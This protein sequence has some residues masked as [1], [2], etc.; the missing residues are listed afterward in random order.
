MNPGK[1]MKGFGS[2]LS[3]GVDTLFGSGGKAGPT[4]A[5]AL[6]KQNPEMSGYMDKQGGLVKSWNRRYF[7]LKGNTLYYFKDRTVRTESKYLIKSH[8][9]SSG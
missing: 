2:K 3:G 8:L 9:Y 7:I 6:M 5:E 4:S 1:K